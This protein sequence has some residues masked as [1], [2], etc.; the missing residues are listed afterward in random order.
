MSS[1]YPNPLPPSSAPSGT[2]NSASSFAGDSQLDPLLFEHV[3]GLGGP[4]D[5][6][7]AGSRTEAQ[8]G[9]DTDDGP[10]RPRNT[11]FQEVIP[12]V[13]DTTGDKVTESFEMFLER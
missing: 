7:P 6:I 5:A 4:H 9:E 10:R 2:P 1:P 13:K 3:H 11:R 8:T 12:P